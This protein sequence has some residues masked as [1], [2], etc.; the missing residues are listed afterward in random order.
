[1][2]RQPHAPPIFFVKL[3]SAPVELEDGPRAGGRSAAAPDL[4]GRFLIAGLLRTAA[5]RWRMALEKFSNQST[6]STDLRSN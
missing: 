4:P 6:E 1:V 3:M 5:G 2:Q